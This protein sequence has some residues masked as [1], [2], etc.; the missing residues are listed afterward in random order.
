[1]AADRWIC[2]TTWAFV[3]LGLVVRLVRYLVVYPIWH[4]EA[5]LAVNLLDRGYV[6]LLRPLDYAQVSPILF[7]WIELTA[8]RLLG[9][10]EWSLRLFPALCGLASVLLFRHIAAR[11]LRGLALVLAVGIFATAF[12]PI[13]HGAEIKPYASDLLSA[14]ILLALAIAC[15]RSP[16][17]SRWWWF[18]TAIVPVL[19]A[20]SYP[21]VFVAA[22]L[23]LALLPDVLR[24]RRPVRLAYLAYN[25]ALAASFACFYF[26][27][28]VIQSTELRSFY[29]W[30]YWRE[31]FPPWEQPWKLPGWLIGVHSGTTLAYPIGGERG[32]S[33]ATLVAFLAGIVVAWRS[34]RRT[35]V[36]LLLAPFGLGLLA[37]GLGQYPYG[38]A[39]RIT[40]YLAPS[41]CLLT[42]LGAAE[43]LSR[44]SSRL[45]RRRLL[46]MAVGFLV[47]IGTFLIARDLIQ[48]YRI[49]TDEASRRFARAFW[50]TDGRDAVFVCV[51]SDLGMVFQPRLW[52]SGM[53]AV[54]LFHRG[55]YA[56]PHARPEILGR[57]GAQPAGSPV[58]LVFFDEIPHDNPLF[59]QWLAGLRPASRIGAVE[60]FMVSPGKPHEAWLRERYVVLELVPQEP[61]QAEIARSVSHSNQISYVV[62]SRGSMGSGNGP[63]TSIWPKCGGPDK[64][65]LK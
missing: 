47:A 23:S 20:L 43:L 39:P 12:Y 63:V 33:T 34:G 49:W 17:R 46:R 30:G 55:M 36:R 3:G 57:S 29:R 50:S 52:K 7:L 58:R 38:G 40:Q 16:G 5:F 11:L 19:L 41:I 51:K 14:L 13:R 60:E 8:A 1:M 48:P 6:D 18:L 28:T 35:P 22:G 2:R 15:W 21:A 53:S 9:F 24:Q 26:A 27:C 4:D 64:L 62:D 37:A 56:H 10:S 32:A 31:S 59:E 42:G 45:W 65:G 54:Y 44:V 25:L 61:I